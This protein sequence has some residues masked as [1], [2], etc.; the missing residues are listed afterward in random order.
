VVIDDDGELVRRL[1]GARPDD[2]VADRAVRVEGLR[3]GEV[4]VERD[5]LIRRD[6]APAGRAAL[7]VGVCAGVEPDRAERRSQLGR[8]AVLEAGRRTGVR[9]VRGR[10]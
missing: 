3:S 6:E 2:E 8:E 4:V 5:V 7:R 9:R 1:V 10:S